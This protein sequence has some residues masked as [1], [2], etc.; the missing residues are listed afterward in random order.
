MSDENK[1]YEINSFRNRF[2]C[3]A[4]KKTL[5]SKYALDNHIVRCYEERIDKY[6]IIL[7]KTE[8]ENIKLKEQVSKLEKIFQYSKELV[9]TID[10]IIKK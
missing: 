1:K 6:E 10:N 2:L 7:K 9:N 3:R 4:C 8:E 5:V